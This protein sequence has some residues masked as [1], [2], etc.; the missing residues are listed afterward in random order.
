MKTAS[1]Y[2]WYLKFK[3][4]NL[5]KE[6]DSYKSGNKIRKM[7]HDYEA[8]VREKDR[9]IRQLEKEVG[10]LHIEIVTVR[11]YWSEIF[12]GVERERKRGILKAEANFLA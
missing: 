1:D 2:I 7:Q 11:K 3:I 12:D 4:T 9:K 6:L 5:E 8:V 10:R